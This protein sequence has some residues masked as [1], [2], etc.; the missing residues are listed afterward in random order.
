MHTR[1]G[2]FVVFTL[3]LASVSIAFAG[4]EVFIGGVGNTC[5]QVF[6]RDAIFFANLDS[7]D[8]TI[9]RAWLSQLFVTKTRPASH[10]EWSIG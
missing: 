6:D 9:E 10:R 1:Y 2:L 3:M 4:D 7:W 8:L 5:I